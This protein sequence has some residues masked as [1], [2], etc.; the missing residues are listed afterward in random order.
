VLPIDPE[1]ERWCPR[2][3]RVLPLDAFNKS[4]A[5]GLQGYCRECQS[6]WYRDHRVQHIANVNANRSRYRGRNE[7]FI[8]EFLLRHPCV[9]CG[10]SDVTILEFDHVAPKLRMIS[11]MR[12]G[13]ATLEAI[14]SEIAKC[15]V[16]CV[17]C[18][19]RRTAMQ[20]AWRKS[21]EALVDPG[22]FEVRG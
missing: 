13:S 6:A 20:F 15:E 9:D 4:T 1:H 5:F 8:R 10:E 2:C 22:M 21:Q 14:K 18:H 3:K 12:W 7:E 19:A 11:E 17:N 16:R